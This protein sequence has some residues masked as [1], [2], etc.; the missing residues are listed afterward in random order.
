MNETTTEHFLVREEPVPRLERIV[1]ALSEAAARCGECSDKIRSALP[2]ALAADCVGCGMRVTGEELLILSRL[3]QQHESS[4]IKRLRTG[5]CARAGC[6][7]DQYLLLL[8]NH[9]DI[10][11]AKLFSA[12]DEKKEEPS[13]SAEAELAVA[14]A[15]WCSARRRKAVRIGLLIV[16]T[17]LLFVLRQYYLGGRIP[18]IREPE[19]FH[20]DPAPPGGEFRRR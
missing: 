18:L 13:V 6:E 11:W 17:I 20:V 5:H 16:A 19:K 15:A 3:P 7:C 8:Q 2:L 14:G 9:P 10:D 4:R 12:G 1:F